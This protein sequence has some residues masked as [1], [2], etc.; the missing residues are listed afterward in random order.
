M[1]LLLNDEVAKATMLLHTRPKPQN[2]PDD[3]D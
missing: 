3:P 1:D 2:I